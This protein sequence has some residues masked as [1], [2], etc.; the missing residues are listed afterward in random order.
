[1]DVASHDA[2][3]DIATPVYDEPAD[4]VANYEEYATP[5]DDLALLM[6]KQLVYLERI[7]DASDEQRISPRQTMI[8]IGATPFSTTVRYRVTEI[9]LTASGATTCGLV[10]GASTQQ[11]FIFSV[12]DTKRFPYITIIDRGVDVSLTGT[13]GIVPTGY[14]IAYPE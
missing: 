13:G 11:S 12:A 6:Q 5:Y 2:L 9:V 1:M 3:R 8:P 14:M 4:V 10:V 7:A